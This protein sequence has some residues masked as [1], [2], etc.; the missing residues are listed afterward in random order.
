MRLAKKIFIDAGHGGESIGAAFGTR[1]EKDDCLRLALAV[2]GLLLTQGVEVRYARAADENPPL[3]SRCEAANAW[4]A[5]YYISLH[6]NSFTDPAANGAEA[7]IWSGCA[8]G[9]ST[10]RKARTILENVCAATGFADRGVKLGAPSYTDFAVNSQTAM[11]SCLLEC[12]FI[13]SPADNRLFDD[14]FGEL[15]RAIAAGLCAAVGVPYSDAPPAPTRIYRVQIGAFYS[16][17]NAEAYAALA[18]EKGF[19]AIVTEGALANS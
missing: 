1:L 17:A 9:G 11:D 13:S 4:G 2:G 16:R 12:G 18:R 8:V 10:Y 7:W 6:R 19:D 3:A 14:T 15:S 5:D